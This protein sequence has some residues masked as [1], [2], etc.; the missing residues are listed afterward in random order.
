MVRKLPSQDVAD[1]AYRRL[2]YVRHADDWLLGFAGPKAEAEEIKTKLQR[3]LGD[4]LKLELSAQKTLITHAGDK[5]A[6]FL[7]YEISSMHAC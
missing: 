5:A 2:H 1:P 7:G 4:H 6:R 3:F